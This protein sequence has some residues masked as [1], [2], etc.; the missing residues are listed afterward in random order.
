VNQ[1]KS[2]TGWN[3]EKARKIL[4][5]YQEQTEVEASAE[6]EAAFE[7]RSQTFMEVPNDLVPEIRSLI[8]KRQNELDERLRT[9]G[10]A[11]GTK[12]FPIDGTDSPSG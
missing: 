9:Q 3:E 12:Y 11:R 8:A 10:Y 4:G 7:D 6:D 2:S 5:H 1:H